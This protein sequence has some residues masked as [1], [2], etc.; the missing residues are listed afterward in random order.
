MIIFDDVDIATPIERQVGS[1][2]RPR[3]LI[4]RKAQQKTVLEI[5]QEIRQ[6]QQESIGDDAQVLG[7]KLSFEEKLTEMHQRFS[8]KWFYW[9][10]EWMVGWKKLYGDV[11][12]HRDWMKGVFPGW[13]IA[14]GGPLAGVA[15]IGGIIKKPGL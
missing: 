12:G 1:E 14:A 9:F 15:A 2:Y 11:W 4:I 6:A 8:K 7:R 10:C 13:V 5:T 3:A